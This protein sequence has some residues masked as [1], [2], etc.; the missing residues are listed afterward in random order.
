MRESRWHGSPTPLLEAQALIFR[1]RTRS[2]PVL[3]DCSLHIR[4]GDRLLL[5]GPSGGGKS[6]LV[7]LLTGLRQPESGLL[8]CG[9]LDQHTLGAAGWRQRVVAAPQFHD[10]HIFAATLAFNLLLG[11]RWPPQPED[12]VAA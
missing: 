5:E 4:A 12:V 11:R 8:L 9:G 7:S 10:N 1:H 2:A 3:Q 6:T